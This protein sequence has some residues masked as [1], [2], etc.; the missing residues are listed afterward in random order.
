MRRRLSGGG[1]TR[2]TDAD[3]DAQ[4]LSAELA[5]MERDQRV[6]AGVRQV[7]HR[8]RRHAGLGVAAGAAVL[9]L[10]RAVFGRRHRA[11]AADA[12]PAAGRN[13]GL[14]RALEI[15]SSMLPGVSRRGLPHGIPALLLS[16]AVPALGRW[17][18][19][20]R[21]QSETVATDKKLGPPPLI[22][23][24]SIDLLRYAGRWYEVAHLPA[25]DR[26]R[27]AGDVSII[28]ELAGR[29]RLSVVSQ[30]RLADGRTRLMSG[31]ARVVP[32]SGNAHFKVSLVPPLLRW[33]PWMWSDQWVLMVDQDY[34]HA[35]VGTPDRK[36]L[37]LL[38]RM[39][40]L[41]GADYDKLIAYARSQ[42]YDVSAV[43]S[44]VE[45]T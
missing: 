15:A 18:V 31:A 40:T 21:R 17:L 16:I 26:Q 22:S 44:I 33:L 38:S 28:Y 13:S 42:G 1:R 35:L 4:I 12:A 6:Q 34:S 25:S 14:I 24:A 45:G 37:Q 2:D 11:A 23:A 5:V 30:Q 7:A 39:P 43:S 9:L 32:R 19:Q 8:V 41:A 36:N 27:H 20:R 3:L 10:A 29:D